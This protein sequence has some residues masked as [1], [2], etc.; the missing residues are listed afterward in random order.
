MREEKFCEQ[1]IPFAGTYGMNDQEVLNCY[2]GSERL[3]LSPDWNCVPSQNLTY[4]GKII[5][6]AG[7]SKPW[8]NRW[9]PGHDEWRKH[10]ASM[11]A[12][13]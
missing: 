7:A 2:A 9:L 8:N 4:T 12:R 6:W 10:E 1:F 11:Q 13:L 3:A 5:H